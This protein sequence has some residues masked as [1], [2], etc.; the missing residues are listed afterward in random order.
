VVDV[1]ELVISSDVTEGAVVT[2]EIIGD[3]MIDMHMSPLALAKLEAY[4]MQALAELATQS[5]RH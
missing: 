1:K 5:P 3:R 2:V 4:V